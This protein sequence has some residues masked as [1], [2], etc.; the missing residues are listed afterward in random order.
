MMREYG[1]IDESHTHM[2]R[3][4]AGCE[5]GNGKGNQ[6]TGCAEFPLGVPYS[7]YAES[8]TEQAD[9]EENQS[10]G[11]GHDYGLHGTGEPEY[12]VGYE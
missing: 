12:D 3:A 1:L 4:K 9:D 5:Q 2:H 7:A 6:K 10:H 11:D 8:E